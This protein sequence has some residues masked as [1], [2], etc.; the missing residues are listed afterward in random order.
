MNSTSAWDSPGTDTTSA[1]QGRDPMAPP[2]RAVTDHQ[3]TALDGAE[4]LDSVHH[5]LAQ[6]NAF[7]SEHCAPM[8]ALWY[9]HTWV[10]EHFYVTPR[11][12]LS[13]AEPGSG[14]TR[15][16]EVAQYLVRAPEMTVSGSAAALFRM[17]GHN[18]ITILFDEVDT[19]F[20]KAGGN[21]DIRGM[22]NAGYK[23]TATIPRCKGDA[24]NI[25][26]ERHPVYAPAALAGI[27]GAMPATITTRAI[28]IHLRRRRTDETVRAFRERQVELEAAP[29]RG[30]LSRWVVAVAE[31]LAVAEPTMPH[32]VADRAAEIWEPLLAIA[33]AAGGHWPETARAA[34][35]HF[36]IDTRTEDTSTGVRLLADLRALFT[37]HNTDRIPTKALLADLIGIEESPWGELDGK[38]LDGRRLAKE[39]ARYNIRPLLFRNAEGTAKG[40]SIHP[41]KEQLG[42]Q[43]AWDRY[44]S[45]L[46]IETG[47][48]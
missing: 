5:Y 8:L 31:Q 23:R 24:S 19:I 43:D 3:A 1:H 46:N 4:V 36:V 9:A 20:T 34:C 39:L 45:P 28:T 32:G 37:R 14:K 41:T 42:L 18:P 33:D 35:T 6:F 16:L 15:V 13:S 44:L 40:Y 2:L 11:L 22:L 21:E 25:T 17:V 29:I 7:P 30:D 48:N 12:I 47:G 26:V 10:S 38:P 27:A